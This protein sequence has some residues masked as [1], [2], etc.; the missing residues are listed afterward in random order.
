MPL[1]AGDVDGGEA[2]CEAEVGPGVGVEHLADQP[3]AGSAE[4]A[5]V[6]QRVVSGVG[7]SVCVAMG[8]VVESG[9]LGPQV[10]EAVV[11]VVVEGQAVDLA[12]EGAVV[13]GGFV[14]VGVLGAQG[15]DV[16]ERAGVQEMEA[17]QGG[18]GVAVGVVFQSVGEAVVRPARFEDEP[19]D[20]RA[21]VA[22]RRYGVFGA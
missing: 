18:D 11:G 16:D 12:E 15:E 8:V 1:F 13:A 7:C 2:G 21:F 10:V 19:G 14:E 17:A 22:V 20:G 6:R 3:G 4:R 9:V 5:L